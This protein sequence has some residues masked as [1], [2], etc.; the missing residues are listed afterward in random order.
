M[1]INHHQVYIRPGFKPL[2][3][4]AVFL[5]RDGVINQETN[6]VHQEKDFQLIP[7]A[8][9]AL[10]FLNQKQIPAIVVHNASVVARN[11]CTESQVESLN[12]LMVQQLLAHKV[13]VDAI[14][15]CPHHPQAYNP[16]YRQDCSWR[17][18]QS[19]MLLAAAKQFN[20]NLT[21]SYLIGDQDRD[22]L[23]GKSVQVKTYLISNGRELLAAINKI[24]L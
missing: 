8:I 23:A 20:L 24:C 6:L 21:K 9:T 11:L 2:K 4:W 16:N 3:N 22:I 10:Q 19:G 18:P 7:E 1:L 12:H 5:D 15:Y 13:F 17:K 14:F